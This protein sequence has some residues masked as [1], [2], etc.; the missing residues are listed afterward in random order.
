MEVILL[1]DASSPLIVGAVLQSK[2]NR[3]Y[4]TIL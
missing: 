1:R 3:P 4:Y 2:S